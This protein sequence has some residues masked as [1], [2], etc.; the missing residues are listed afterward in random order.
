MAHL[1]VAKGE[2]QALT[3]QHKFL[4]R[5]I[6]AL[7]CMLSWPSVDRPLFHKMRDLCKGGFVEISIRH[8]DPS[9][10][11]HPVKFLSTVQKVPCPA[12]LRDIMGSMAENVMAQTTL[13]TVRT[14]RHKQKQKAFEEDM[15]KLLHLRTQIRLRFESID[16]SLKEGFCD[17]K[18]VLRSG[19]MAGIFNP[20]NR[21][22]TTFAP[23]EQ[24]KLMKLFARNPKSRILEKCSREHKIAV[25]NCVFLEMAQPHVCF[26]R[27]GVFTIL[28]VIGDVF[29]LVNTFT[30]NQ[31]E[32]NE[33]VTM[34][35][36]NERHLFLVI[37]N[38]T[39]WI[40]IVTGLEVEKS[41]HNMT[42]DIVWLPELALRLIP[43]TA[44]EK[45]ENEARL[46]KILITFPAVLV[47]L[48]IQFLM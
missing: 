23:G 6:G 43:P 36:M 21:I 47:N 13:M 4:G 30:V 25:E 8:K 12:T 1:T 37:R 14:A 33:T 16:D 7:E 42:S 19:Q 46:S 31:I 11:P 18:L 29:I 5:Q 24:D 9:Q 15:K 40:D 39:L 20:R 10:R 26:R 48:C 34:V 3:I 35:S 22:I 17:Q 28:K 41:P 38:I 45:T 32:K 27:G 2:L 44:S